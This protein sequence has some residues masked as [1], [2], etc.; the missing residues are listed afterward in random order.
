MREMRHADK[1][2]DAVEDRIKHDIALVSEFFGKTGEDFIKIDDQ[3]LKLESVILKI[4]SPSTDDSSLAAGP[5]DLLPAVQSDFA[6]LDLIL[7]TSADDFGTLGLDFLKL[8]KGEKAL[9]LTRRPFHPISTSLVP[10]CHTSWALASY[11]CRRQSNRRPRAQ[12]GT[13]Y[14]TSH[15]ATR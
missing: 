13:D 5:A 12:E 6:K 11:D 15:P 3:V 14:P 2:A 1:I 7:K 8:D 4:S 10:I 9:S